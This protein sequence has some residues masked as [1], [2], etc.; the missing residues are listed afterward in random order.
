MKTPW[1]GEN[2]SSFSIPCCLFCLAILSIIWGCCYGEL[3]VQ[4]SPLREPFIRRGL[5]RDV[6]ISSNRALLIALIHTRGLLT[7]LFVFDVFIMAS[8]SITT[9]NMD[10][11]SSPRY[12][13]VCQH[14]T[15]NWQHIWF[16]SSI[17]SVCLHECVVFW[18]ARELRYYTGCFDVDRAC[19]FFMWSHYWPILEGGA[20]LPR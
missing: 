16:I 3:K 15:L 12:V 2:K 4:I 7:L 14:F 6:I 5:S 8:G 9:V 18:E 19:A 20:H 11:S 13:N 1:V 10:E 17:M